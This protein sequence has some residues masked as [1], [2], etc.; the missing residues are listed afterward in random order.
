MALEPCYEE[1]NKQQQKM[2]FRKGEKNKKAKHVW[3]TYQGNVNP[4][5]VPSRRTV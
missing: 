2:S 1:K 4:G 5:E 3:D